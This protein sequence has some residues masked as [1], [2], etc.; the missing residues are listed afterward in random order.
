MYTYNDLFRRAIRAS[1]GYGY[2]LFRAFEK[3]FL[4]RFLLIQGY[5]NSDLSGTMTIRLDKSSPDSTGRL[6][7]SGK[8]NNETATVVDRVI[9]KLKRNKR[10]FGAVPLSMLLKMGEPGRGFHSGGSFPMSCN[11][12]DFETDLFGRPR[13]LKRIHIVDASTFPSIPAS[14][15]TFTA[16]ANAHRIASEK[17]VD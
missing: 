17:F 5:L 11:P 2:P 6:I 12:K 3:H 7:V 13:G 14:T 15:I 10:L 4:N 8:V 1:L 9:A 16:M